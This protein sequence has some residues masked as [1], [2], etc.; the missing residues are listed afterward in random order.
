MTMMTEQQWKQGRELYEEFCAQL[1]YAGDKITM[2][3]WPYLSPAQ[4][5]AWAGTAGVFGVGLSPDE[6][7]YVPSW[8]PS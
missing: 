4:Q 1:A 5:E 6:R 3:E 7:P 8:P 2:T